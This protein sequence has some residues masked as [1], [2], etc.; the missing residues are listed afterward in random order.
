MHKMDENN[1]S[2]QPGGY[3]P[4]L[5]QPR[6]HAHGLRT[7]AILVLTLLIAAVFVTGLFAGWEFGTRNVRSTPGSLQSGNTTPNADSTP[8]LPAGNADTVDA[9]RASIVAK[10]RPAVVQVNVNGQGGNS[11]GSGVII[12]RRGYIITNNH[13]IEGSQ[14]VSV[15]LS[16]GTMLPAQIA[17]K[18]PADDL[19][20]L[21]VDPNKAKLSV[22]A[23]GDSSKLQVGQAVMAIGNPL[24]ITQTVTSGIVSALG[25]NVPTG[26]SGALLPGTIQ[27]D[28]AINSGNSGGALVDLQGNLVGI[29]TL[30]A[31]DPQ[32]RTPANG[33]GFAIP[34]NRV[35]F[36]APQ[37]IDSGKV[38]RTGRAAL[39]VQIAPV[40]PVIAA[41]NNLPI[42]RGVLIVEFTSN[43]AAEKAG[44]RSGD[45][46]TQI[47]ERAVDGILS[48][49]DALVSKNPGDRASVRVYRGNQQLTMPVTL[50]ELAA[51]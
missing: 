47:D 36:I 23:I 42:D 13:V 51:R 21:K 14:N 41:R 45:I 27:T 12:D 50:G 33:V 16:D 34:A 15:M 48:L 5:V 40:D 43:S 3:S 25:R 31:I 11:V 38:T 17:G 18:A 10:V 44:L 35:Q 8:A 9:I 28:A 2:T 24:G 30:T 26:D 46:I 22:A 29:P 39:G 20:I 49:N 37:L 32:F 4:E 7:G 1:V 19:A 6:K